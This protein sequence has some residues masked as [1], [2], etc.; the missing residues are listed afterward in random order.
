MIVHRKTTHCLC[1]TKWKT[2]LY[3]TQLSKKKD[4]I[5]ADFVPGPL[6]NFEICMNQ[7]T[8]KNMQF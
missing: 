8:V 4:F 1:I 3:S 6:G 7:R 2:P 5:L